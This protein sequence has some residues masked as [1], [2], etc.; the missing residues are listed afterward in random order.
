MQS[1]KLAVYP[2]SLI[3]PVDTQINSAPSAPHPATD[4]PEKELLR[5]EN[6]ELRQQLKELMSKLDRLLALQDPGSNGPAST[7]E[8]EK[9]RKEGTR[10]QTTASNKG[11]TIGSGTGGRHIPGLDPTEAIPPCPQDQLLSRPEEEREEEDKEGGEWVKIARRGAK[12]PPPPTTNRTPQQVERAKK[13]QASE[14]AKNLEAMLHAPPPPAEFTSVFFQLADPRPIRMAKGR[15][16]DRLLEMLLKRLDIKSVTAGYSL[17]PNNVIQLIV[18][19]GAV[20]L[21]SITLKEVKATV[22]PALTSAERVAPPKY[23]SQTDERANQLTALR[24]AHFCRQSRARRFHE[25]VLMGLADQERDM[26]LQMYRKI[27]DEP[28]AMLGHAGRWYDKG[29][30]PVLTS[31]DVTMGGPTTNQQ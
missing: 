2:P 30:G 19:K 5:R 27:M 21:V 8:A 25:E 17:L 16:K 10:G 12:A 20:N 26:V 31:E 9:G 13:K 22:L 18:F 4:D 7:K 14:R 28:R 3:G 23:T 29:K 6:A 15:E 1:N 11:Q 24:L